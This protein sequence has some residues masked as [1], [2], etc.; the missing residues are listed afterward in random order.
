MLNPFPSLYDEPFVLQQQPQTLIKTHCLETGEGREGAGWVSGWAVLL[1]Y[2]QWVPC[3]INSV[4]SLFVLSY[5]QHF[6][7]QLHCF[8]QRL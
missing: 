4:L 1:L 2:F 8:N 3:A 7:H 5:I 6:N